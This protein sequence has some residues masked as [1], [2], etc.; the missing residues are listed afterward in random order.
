MPEL[1][2]IK[3]HALLENEPFP[4]AVYR[5]ILELQ[6]CDTDESSVPDSADK[7]VQQFAMEI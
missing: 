5:L 3:N 1:D 2:R 7:A 6:I 4:I